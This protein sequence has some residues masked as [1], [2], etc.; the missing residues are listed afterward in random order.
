MRRIT[1]KGTDYSEGS[2]ITRCKDQKIKIKFTA[3]TRKRVKKRV[4]KGLRKLAKEE[5]IKWAEKNKFDKLVEE[6]IFGDIQKNLSIKLKKIYPLSTFEI[7]AIK[8]LKEKY[9]E[10]EQPLEETSE[11]EQPKEENTESNKTKEEVEK[12]D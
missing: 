4:L 5:L 6:I 11:S 9:E 3:I 2:F 7:K 1:R 10:Q 12:N 8:I